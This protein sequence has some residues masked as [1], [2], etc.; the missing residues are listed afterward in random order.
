M[1]LPVH[2]GTCR[3]ILA[4]TSSREEQVLVVVLVPR[5]MGISTAP[6]LIVHVPRSRSRERLPYMYVLSGGALVVT[7]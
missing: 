5:Y 3:G 7:W 6:P 1:Y 2:V 4:S